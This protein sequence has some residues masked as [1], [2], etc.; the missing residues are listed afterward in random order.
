MDL[1][2]TKTLD[3]IE[4]NLHQPL[5]LEE[6]SEVACL[7]PSQFH[8]IFKKETRRTPFIFIEELKMAKAYELISAGEGV[9]HELASKLG[10]K[11][12]ETFTRAFKKHF[13]IS[14][15]DLKSIAKKVK[16]ILGDEEVLIVTVEDPQDQEAIQQKVREIMEKKGLP[17]SFL[18]FAKALMIEEKS[19]TTP[20]ERLIKNKYQV[21]SSHK[22]WE[23]LINPNK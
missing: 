14:P 15:D 18:N 17:M 20:P 5:T 6:L 8:R 9:V 7:S 4:A 10:Y 16:S 19:P 1:R 21:T 12:Y 2:I 22:I 13:F 3:H 23:S 11:D